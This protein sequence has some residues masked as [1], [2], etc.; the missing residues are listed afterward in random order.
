[1][2]IIMELTRAFKNLSKN[3]AEI[4]GG[5]GASLG[6]MTQAGIPVPPGFVVLADTFEQF[7]HATDLVQE[8]DAIL[9][10]VDHKEIHTVE[11]ASEK[12][13]GLIK[14]A[15]TP[16][17]IKNAILKDFDELNTEF[18]AVRSS[19]TA[20]DGQD[21]AWAGQ[22]DS[23]L[24][25]KKEHVLEKVQHCWA[26]LFTPRAIFYRFEKG[27]DTTKISVAVVIQKMV[28]S[29]VS[30]IAF[31][32][33]PVTEDRNQLIIEAGFGLGESIVSGQITPDSYV[34]EKEPRKIIDI[35]ISEQSRGL[36]RKQGG[37]NEWKE[38]GE[39]G[40]QQVLAKTQIDEL[41]N[42][43][44]TIE[45]HYRFPCDIEWALEEGKFYIVQ[46]RPITT[47]S[48]KIQ[49]FNSKEKRIEYSEYI[50]LFSTNGMSFLMSDIF[51]Q[52]Y[53]NM[54]GLAT[55]AH[56]KWTSFLPKNV[57]TKTLEEGLGLYGDKNKFDD[58]VEN[59]DLYYKDSAM[60]FEKVLNSD[61]L[62]KESTL[63]FLDKMT[64]N[65]VH[66]SKTEFFYVDLAFQQ[67]SNNSVVADNLKKFEIIK[68]DSRLKVNK[69][70]F[71]PDSY[72]K[73]LMSKICK[74]FNLNKDDISS[75]GKLDLLNLF[76]GIKLSELCVRDRE[77]SYLMLGNNGLAT[78]F[79][80]DESEKIIDNFFSQVK[81]T[82]N[83]Q[84]KGITARAGKVTAPATV[85]KYGDDMFSRLS[86][87]IKK[88]PDGN[89]LVT[90]TTS[91][92][93]LMACK[94]SSAIL[95]N[96]GGMMSHAAI[97]SRELNIPCIVGLGSVTDF[98]K[99]GDVVE[100]DADNGIIRIIK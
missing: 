80:G 6:E 64:E 19:A 46:S 57:V 78:Y 67:S 70:F 100:V 21:H 50:Q 98:V 49:N 4:A 45:N 7:L 72:R 94:K 89:V 24:N 79:E 15:Q 61:I 23:Y 75:Y 8:I 69:I 11:S 92:E 32:V 59:M 99:D 12:I 34:V 10:T 37:D 56:N 2:L 95:T 91:P 16:E 30:G 38:L 66:Y 62:T 3:D 53:K 27:L 96:Q 55:F 74:Q 36:F 25:I 35:N 26:S 43:I 83:D 47:L 29:E 77:R 44:L 60:L 14:N 97:V 84:L 88:M 51:I 52:Y 63:V 90:D 17:D 85:I 86:D 65:F 68:N 87:V 40:K 54:D 48:S 42:I 76:D 73:Q 31:S 81:N 41:S 22:L 58:F 33:H 39:Q 82:T 1:M 20:E 9:E 28:N 5:K 13:Q 71:Q 93:L 18:V